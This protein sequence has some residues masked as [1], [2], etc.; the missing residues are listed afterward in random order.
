[1]LSSQ[2]PMVGLR[3]AISTPLRLG[4][5]RDSGLA[6]SSASWGGLNTRPAGG[7]TSLPWAMTPPGP[8]NL[9]GE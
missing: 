3:R 4:R 7:G 5:N 6:I 9:K 8:A 1:M 2:F